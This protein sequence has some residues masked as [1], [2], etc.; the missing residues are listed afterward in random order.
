MR[1]KESFKIAIIGLGY[2]GLPLARLFLEKGHTVFGVDSSES[3]IQKLQRMQPYLSDMTSMD[4]KE[5]FA[6]GKF[7]VGVSYESIPEADCVILC[8]PTPTTEEFMPDLTFVFQAMRQAVPYLREGQLI[9]LE[10]STY[11]GT[12]EEELKPIIE[13]RG[14]RVGKDVYLAYSPERINPGQ[15]ASDLK[16]IPK[17]LGGVTTECTQQ[18]KRIYA[19]VFDQVVPVSNPRTAELTKLVEN[20]QRF[21]N[22]SF[23]NDLVKFCDT[24]EINLWEVINAAG[25]KPYG[26]MAYYPGPGVGGHCI[27]VDP[28]YLLWKA[29]QYGIKMPFIE[30][31]HQVNEGMPE[32]IVAR[33]AKSMFPL[34]LDQCSI[35]AV[36]VTYKKDVNDV[37]E[38]MALKVIERLMQQGAQVS[39]FDPYITELSI[40]GTKLERSALTA[41]NVNEKDCLLILTDH[42]TI[43]YEELAQHAKLIVDLRNATDCVKDKSN[44]VLL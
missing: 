35:M 32:Y 42:S 21:I 41:E 28:M 6:G 20:C 34:S 11:P 33:T 38:S 15:K 30:L 9:V 27:P 2:V 14:L 13:Q 12:T 3:K 24:M 4:L 44:I 43:N 39:F 22:I 5:M 29:N 37:R 19:S 1:P 36:G 18:A 16:S 31:S 23:M 26:F 40:A 17:V 8:V 25:T 10:S 7:H